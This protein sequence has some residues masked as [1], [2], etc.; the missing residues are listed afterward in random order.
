V[1]LNDI[2]KNED[3]IANFNSRIQEIL[4]NQTQR[5][6]YKQLQLSDV[7]LQTLLINIAVPSMP[8]D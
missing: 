3:D 2:S 8:G 5:Y 6:L 4:D 7:Q 1:Q